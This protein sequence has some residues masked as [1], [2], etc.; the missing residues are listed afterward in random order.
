[1]NPRTLTRRG[2]RFIAGWEGYIPRPYYDELGR[3]WTVGY[4][5]TFKPNGDP[6]T[7]YSPIYLPRWRARRW[8]RNVAQ[9]AVGEWI[10]DHTTVGLN[11]NE[12]DALVSFGYNCG[13]GAL[14][15][16]ELWEKLQR[17]DRQA[18]ADE[19]LEWDKAWVNGSLQSVWGL[20]RRRR[21]E[22]TMFLR[23][24]RQRRK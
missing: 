18:A 12:F 9:Q 10:N 22:R 16:S 3:V 15:G 23:K 21:A 4:G 5:S 24:P 2:A 13:I 17:G 8:L 1:M 14:E 11:K 20:T 19:F 7:Q 6:V